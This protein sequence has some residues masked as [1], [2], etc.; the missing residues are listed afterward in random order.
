MLLDLKA[1]KEGK[2]VKIKDAAKVVDEKRETMVAV[3]I[4]FLTL[5]LVLAPGIY[6]LGFMQENRGFDP[7]SHIA[8]VK[9]SKAQVTESSTEK[10]EA[11]GPV[12]Y[13]LKNEFNEVI[14]KAVG[15]DRNDAIEALFKELS[16]PRSVFA[17]CIWIMSISVISIWRGGS[18]RCA[19][20]F[21]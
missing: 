1:L 2:R 21:S 17:E 10:A 12:T 7:H 13:E 8:Q 5:C 15:R 11:A 6:F 14:Y 19:F 20:P 4:V 18:F 9:Q 16:K 3:G